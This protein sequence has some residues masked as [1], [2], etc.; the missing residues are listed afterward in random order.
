MKPCPHCNY[1]G[2][3]QVYSGRVMRVYCDC[4]A[5]DKC[6]ADLK[7]ALEEVGLDPENPDYRWPRRSDYVPPKYKTT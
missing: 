7:K 3:V 1:Y 2:E 5:G 4:E 6:I